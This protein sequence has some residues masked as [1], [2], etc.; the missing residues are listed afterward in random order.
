MADTIGKIPRPTRKLDPTY[1]V[2][3]PQDGERFVELRRVGTG[4]EVVVAYHGPAAGH[5]DEAALQVLSG[6]MSGSG[7]GGGRG[8]RGGGGGGRSDGRLAKALVDTK[9]AQSASMNFGV[10]A[11]PGP[12]DGYRD[13]SPQM[14]RSTKPRRRMLDALADVVKNPP[15]K[16]DSRQGP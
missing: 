5:P 6:I 8:G 15:T 14:S 12:G 11:R 4:Q 3:P 13:T 9:K 2:E 7:G 16:E 10:A 1:T